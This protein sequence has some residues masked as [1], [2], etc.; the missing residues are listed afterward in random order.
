[1]HKWLVDHVKI[2]GIADSNTENERKR[3]N[4]SYD[5]NNDDE[6]KC[7]IGYAGKTVKIQRKHTKIEEKKMNRTLPIIAWNS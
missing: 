5:D 3:I 4:N 2:K 1:M 6:N 7:V